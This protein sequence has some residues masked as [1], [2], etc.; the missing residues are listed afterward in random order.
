MRKIETPINPQVFPDGCA[1]FY[2][3][4]NI[5]GNGNKPIFKTK[6]MFT[7]PFEE[8]KVGDVRYYA[9]LQVDS[10]ISKVIRIPKI[11]GIQP[12]GDIVVLSGDALQYRV[13][14]VSRNTLTY[15]ESIDVTLEV[16]K[17]TYVLLEDEEESD[18]TE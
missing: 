13:Q 16:S 12:A 17:H 6:K 5:A 7:C 14:K 10:T 8:K 3:Q 9:S 18:D 2:Q 11:S 15:P 1:T 4:A